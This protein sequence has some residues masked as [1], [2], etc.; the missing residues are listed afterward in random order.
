MADTTTSSVN[1]PIIAL[2]NKRSWCVPKLKKVAAAVSLDTS[3]AASV[4][5]VVKKSWFKWRSSAPSV[6]A[7]LVQ[8]VAVEGVEPVLEGSLKEVSQPAVPQ[9]D[10]VHSWRY[11][12][13]KAHGSCT[14]ALSESAPAAPDAPVAPDAPA[15]PDA[16]VASQAQ[17]SCFPLFYAAHAA[18][19]PSPSAE[20]ILEPVAVVGTRSHLRRCGLKKK[21]LAKYPR[22]KIRCSRSVSATQEP[23]ESLDLRVAESN[24]EVRAPGE[25]LDQDPS[26]PVVVEGSQ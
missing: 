10:L 22:I 25:V 23:Q 18:P 4:E 17:F 6:P 13:Y 7:Q 3:V 21:F 15:V 19:S 5:K 24:T 16:P 9:V 1:D 8:P 2:A 12:C 20:S 26:K 14:P 11:S